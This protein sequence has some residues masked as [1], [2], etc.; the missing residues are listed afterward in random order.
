MPF[1]RKKDHRESQRGS[2]VIARLAIGAEACDGGIGAVCVR[3]RGDGFEVFVNAGTLPD[4]HEVRDFGSGER[5]LE[6]AFA[7]ALHLARELAAE[8]SSDAAAKPWEA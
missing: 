8:W 3:D 5:A 6:D 1:A 7:Y 2:L 4:G